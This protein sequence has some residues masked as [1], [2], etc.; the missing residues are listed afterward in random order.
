[1][2]KQYLE[3][4]KI[5]GTHGIRGMVRVQPWSDSGEFLTNFKRFYLSSKGDTELQVLKVQPHGGVVLIAIKGVDSVERAEALRGKTLY[6][7]RDDI[8]LPEGRYF[9]DD[10][11][12]CEVFDAD[13]D[14]KYGVISEV[15]QTGANDVWHIKS[16]GKEYLLPAIDEVIVSVSP[17]KE[18]IE[19]RPMKGIFNDED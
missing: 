2:I 8:A 19:I 9:I 5:V 1:M 16:G 18:R 11:I 12:G 7:S 13:S 15:S 3:T 4:G 10:L 17:E 14:E 6:I